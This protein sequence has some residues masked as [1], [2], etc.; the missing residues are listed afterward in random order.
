MIEGQLAIR[1]QAGAGRAET[2]LARYRE[3]GVEAVW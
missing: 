1:H 2:T 3:A